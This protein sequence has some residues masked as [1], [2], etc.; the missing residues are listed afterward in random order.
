M[1]SPVYKF[2]ERKWAEEFVMGKSVR[3]GSISGFRNIEIHK[4][5]KG[6]ESE[7]QIGIRKEGGLTIMRNS[8]L[9]WQLASRGIDF[10]GINCDLRGAA[11]RLNVGD[12][13]VFCC[14]IR[15]G[16]QIAKDLDASYDTCVRIGNP[17][18][19]AHRITDALVRKGMQVGTTML[20]EVQYV[21]HTVDENFRFEDGF[22]LKR[23]EYQRQRE[24]RFVWPIEQS[25]S[26]IDLK[27]DPINCKLKLLS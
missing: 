1:N 24:F 16:L 2:F 11:V 20:R 3:L 21:G 26:H 13:L 14:S 4:L 22:F 10:D 5:K 12:A 7:G 27:F 6:D 8:V 9:G 15:D 25:I 18:L 17:K 19:L 23:S